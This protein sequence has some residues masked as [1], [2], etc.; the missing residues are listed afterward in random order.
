MTTVVCTPD[1]KCLTIT[2]ETHVLSKGDNAKVLSSSDIK[3][4]VQDLQ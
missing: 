2:G 4:K 1:K 3:L